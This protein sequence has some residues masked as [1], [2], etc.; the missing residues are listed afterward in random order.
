MCKPREANAMT[1]RFEL[2]SQHLPRLGQTSR[3]TLDGSQPA[4]GDGSEE[5]GTDIGETLG[6]DSVRH[7]IYGV[8][9][10]DDLGEIERDAVGLFT[11]QVTKASDCRV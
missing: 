9:L 4:R 2:C 7:R 10:P 11:D 3:C 8:Q 5:I 1:L 6:A